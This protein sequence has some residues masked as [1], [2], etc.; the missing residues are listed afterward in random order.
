M[1]LKHRHAKIDDN[2]IDHTVTAKS[3]SGQ[4]GGGIEE[5]WHGT[6]QSKWEGTDEWGRDASVMEDMTGC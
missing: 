4:G 6:D 3:V 1:P 5:R 2:K